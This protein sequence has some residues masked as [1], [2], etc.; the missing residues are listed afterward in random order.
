MTFSF[1]ATAMEK[2]YQRLLIIK[3]MLEQKRDGD[4]ILKWLTKHDKESSTYIDD[5]DQMLVSAKKVRW[6]KEKDYTFRITKE[7][8]VYIDTLK[9]SKELKSYLLGLIAMAKI[10]KIKKGLPTCNP[11]DRGYAWYI[12]TGLTNYSEGEQ[13]KHQLYEFFH[14]LT[15]KD[16]IKVQSFTKKVKRNDQYHTIDV[17]NIILKAKWVDFD[18][19]KGYKVKNIEK[20][21]K[22]ICK[23]YLTDDQSVCPKCGKLF[24]KSPKAKTELCSECYLQVRKEKVALNVANLRQKREC[25]QEKQQF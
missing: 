20:D 19:K 12:A 8:I 21:I 13:K 4:Y 17:T 7:E 10:M 25:N 9:Y 6:P 2:Q 5:I 16:I 18:A 1:N 23:K 24:V 15:Q 11:R 3:L 22:R 14:E